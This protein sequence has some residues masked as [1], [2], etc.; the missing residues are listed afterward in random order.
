MRLSVKDLG[1]PLA[2]SELL[3]GFAFQGE[4]PQLP[5]DV[6]LAP[7]FRDSVRGELREIKV[8]DAARG[9]HARVVVI[10]L[11]KRGEADLERVRRVSALGAL[12][13]DALGA[14]S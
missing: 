9:K 1:A 13:A 10:G 11:G 3:V 5:K 4:A 14:T 6:R 8:T 7:P 12:R 2:R